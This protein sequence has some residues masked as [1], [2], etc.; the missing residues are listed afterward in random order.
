MGK[1]SRAAIVIKGGAAPT[2][3]SPAV[4]GIPASYYQTSMAYPLTVVEAVGIS[5]V[6]RCVTL[7]ANAIAGQRWTEWTDSPRERI[8]PLTTIVRRPSAIMTRREWVWRVVASMALD[9]I[10][11]LYL[12]GGVDDEGIPGSLIPLPR[13]LL[14]PAG[15]SDP[16]GIFPP[17]K[18]LLGG[19]EISA[20]FIIPVRSAFWPGVPYHLIGILQM[21]RNSMMTAFA[22]DTYASRYWQ[23]GGSP[24]TVITTEQELN[25]TQADDI[26]ARWRDRRSRGP[27]YPAVLGKGA[28]AKPWG[29]D[30]SNAVAIEAR[31]E[32]IIEVAN[33]FGVNSQYLNVS[34]TGTSKTYSNVQDEALSLERF[35]LSGFV[36][37][38]QDVISDLLPD[39]RFMLIDMTR[40]TRAAQESRF[41]SWQI[42][43]GMKAWMLPS[44]VRT[45]EGL[46]P[47][48]GIDAMET[49][50]IEG[51]QNA[52]REPADDA[53]T[54]GNGERGSD[55]D[56]RGNSADSARLAAV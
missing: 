47:S 56:G 26:G 12:T 17:T 42:A 39:D 27:D 13:Q 22:S 52:V 24:T 31:R 29:A 19:E 30:I 44:E 2:P 25:A 34:P 48:D 11:Y 20:E 21:A 40:L 45:E 1:K 18:Y 28:E 4:L 6:R 7:I 9:D 51:A 38:I 14:A 53:G 5:A 3:P 15:Y 35:T 43:T 55:A 33:L 16:Y 36:D 49:A 37:P 10:S 50:A 32:I 46:S 54:A 41:R 23:A 8:E